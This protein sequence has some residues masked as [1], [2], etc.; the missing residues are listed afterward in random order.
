[1]IWVFLWELFTLQLVGIFIISLSEVH[2][3]VVRLRMYNFSFGTGGE[4]EEEEEVIL[5][6]EMHEFWNENSLNLITS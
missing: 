4:E 3:S 1:M 2:K 6:W 5:K